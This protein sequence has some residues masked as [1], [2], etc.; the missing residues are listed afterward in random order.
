MKKILKISLA[1]LCLLMSGSVLKAQSCDAGIYM[2][3]LG[4][5]STATEAYTTVRVITDRLVYRIRVGDTTCEWANSCTGTFVTSRVCGMTLL[6]NLE[7][8]VT[9]AQSC[10]ARA[11]GCV[12]VVAGRT[13]SGSDPGSN[14]YN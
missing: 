12:V 11:D 4:Q 1:C 14:N 5:T 9:V 10:S 2:I 8:F 13:C 7:C 6:K 3:P